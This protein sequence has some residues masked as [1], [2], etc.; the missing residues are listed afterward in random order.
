VPDDR[1]APES[2]RIGDPRR[3]RSDR[4]ITLVETMVTLAL[5]A[6]V[7]VPILGLL[8]SGANSEA[9]ATARVTAINDGATALDRIG[10]DIRTA[11]AILRNR[12]GTPTGTAL[13]LRVRTKSGTDQTVEWVVS[14][15]SLI[16]SELDSAGN[17]TA[18][19][20]VLDRLVTG[21]AG[22]TFRILDS[23]GRVLDASATSPVD[24]TACGALVR[25]AI[26]QFV[27]ESSRLLS[28]DVA[29]R[30]SRNG[31]TC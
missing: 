29:L 30:N 14:G 22:T 8:R 4:G 9:R 12:P 23:Q 10:N 25:V 2:D 27:N 26:D 6:V 1:P 7:S 13:V 5:L 19:S 3:R 28:I 11:N 17:T 16:R 31:G 20:T 18:S 21:S 24:L 15:G